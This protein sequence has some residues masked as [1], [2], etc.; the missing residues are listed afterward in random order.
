MTLGWRL[1]RH[2]QARRRTVGGG[3]SGLP[4]TPAVRGSSHRQS[5]VRG[6][7]PQCVYAQQLA[8]LCVRLRW[9]RIAENVRGS[10]LRRRVAGTSRGGPAV[11]GV[12]R[13]DGRAKLVT[14]RCGEFGPD[15][16]GEFAGDRRGD[17]GLGLFAGSEVTEPS[18]QPE[19]GGPRPGGHGRVDALLAATQVGRH[20][21]LVAV[22]P[23]RLDEL[24]AHV[25]VAGPGDLTAPRVSPLEYSRGTSPQNPMNDGAVGK[26][27]KSHTST[28]IV[29][30]PSV[31]I[32][33]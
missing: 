3:L 29:N 28:A 11:A 2:R 24:G 23:G 12:D 1:L 27:R 15:E 16:P 26:R 19:L 25:Y 13:R 8:P 20:V 10:V 18:T 6:S 32:P 4:D 17:G 22:R 5:N 21:G 14:S 31:S 7:G 30:A 33:R 9:H